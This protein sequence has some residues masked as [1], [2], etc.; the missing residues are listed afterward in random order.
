MRTKGLYQHRP[1]IAESWKAAK[2]G[3]KREDANPSVC[4]MATW[5]FFARSAFLAFFLAWAVPCLSFP[6]CFSS[7]ISRY[8]TLAYLQR[9]LATTSSTD[10]TMAPST[11][12]TLHSTLTHYKHPAWHPAMAQHCRVTHHAA[13]FCVTLQWH[14]AMAG[15]I[16]RWHPG[17]LDPA[18]ALNNGIQQCHSKK[19]KQEPL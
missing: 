11:G 9:H 13:C 15:G 12:T 7:Q 4:N 18:M 3:N 5:G 16:I 1:K 6:L 10:F 14:P 2:E 19:L 17:P 8:A